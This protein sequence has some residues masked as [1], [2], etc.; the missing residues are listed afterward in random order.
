MNLC[1]FK[2]TLGEPGVGFHAARIGPF[3]LWDTVGTLAIAYLLNW[4]L[5]GSPVKD[6]A[7]IA[8]GLF[9]FGQFLH[10][11]FCVDTAF[12]KMIN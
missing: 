3:A 12:M 4:S 5:G 2:D 8:F 1:R 7:K 9:I 6:F 11:L 10:W